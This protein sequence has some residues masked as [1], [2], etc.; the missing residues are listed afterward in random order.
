MRFNEQENRVLERG[1]SPVRLEPVRARIELTRG[2]EPTV[3]LLDHDG[4]PT[5]QTLPVR[6]GA[7]EI[8]GTR[9]RTPYYLIRYR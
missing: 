6:G 2:G 7:F 1:D 3:E 4:F 8:D 5:G 9:D